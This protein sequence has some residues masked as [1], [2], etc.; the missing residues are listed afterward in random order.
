MA[1]LWPIITARLLTFPPQAKIREGGVEAR[2][3]FCMVGFGERCWLPRA[4]LQSQVKWIVSTSD[5]TPRLTID[6]NLTDI[7]IFDD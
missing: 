7:S 4:R 6:N 3:Q 2:E 1:H 5:V